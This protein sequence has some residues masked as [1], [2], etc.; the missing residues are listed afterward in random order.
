MAMLRESSTSTATTFCC[1]RNVATLSAGCHR[2]NRMSATMQV[3]STQIATGR[4]PLSTPWL[5]R[6]C[7]KSSPAAARMPIAMSHRGQGVRKTNVPLWK[8]LSGYLKRISNMKRTIR[9]CADDTVDAVVG[10]WS[11]KQSRT[12][13]KFDMRAH[14]REAL[15]S[16]RITRAGT[17]QISYH[18]RDSMPI[19]GVIKKD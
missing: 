3:S 11:Y 13:G 6:T 5:R 15:V 2:R 17:S 8:M 7:Q 1:G 18:I 4:K 12:A 16:R 14:F 10:C 19:D 9:D